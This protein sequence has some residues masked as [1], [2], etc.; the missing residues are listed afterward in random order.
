VEC[1]ITIFVKLE[2]IKVVFSARDLQGEFCLYLTSRGLCCGCR[3]AK[4]I[5][6]K[7][8]FLIFGVGEFCQTKK[9]YFFGY[10][11]LGQS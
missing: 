2:S 11:F 7:R 1:G 4:E 8:F 3:Y 9:A 10:A 5:L 6:Q